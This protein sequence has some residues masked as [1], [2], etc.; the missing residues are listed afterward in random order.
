MRSNRVF[1][2]VPA[3][4]HSAMDLAVGHMN[5]V[6]KWCMLVADLGTWTVTITCFLS[7]FGGE[8]P[9]ELITGLSD[10]SCRTQETVLD[11]Y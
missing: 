4:R 10:E 6:L 8:Y 9:P 2:E 3:Q 11:R 5:V 7:F 1:Q